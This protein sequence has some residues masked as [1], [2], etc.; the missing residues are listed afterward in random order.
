[1]AAIEALWRTQAAAAAVTRCAYHMALLD[2]WA[3]KGSCPAPEE[4]KQLLLKP[5]IRLRT[6]T[7]AQSLFKLAES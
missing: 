4:D 7:H 3:V 2:S 1:M 6:T 5:G